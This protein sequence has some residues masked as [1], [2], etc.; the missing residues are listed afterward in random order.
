MSTQ[1]S[2]SAHAIPNTDNHARQTHKPQGSYLVYKS[3]ASVS[4]RSR[5]EAGKCEENN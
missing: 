2:L 3:L 5:G 4:V 1:Q